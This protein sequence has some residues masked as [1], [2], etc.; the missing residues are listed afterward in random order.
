MRAQIEKTRD[1]GKDAQDS[2]RAVHSI[3]HNRG[4]GPIIPDDVDTPADD[5]FSSGNSPSLSHSSV[6]NSRESTKAKSRKRPSHLPAL[7]DVISGAF[8]RARKEVG[9]RQNQSVQVPRNASVLLEGTMPPALSA[10]MIPSMLFVHPAFG[11][12]PT[13]YMPPTAL[14]PLPD[15]MLSSPMGQHILD[16]E[17]P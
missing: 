17:P 1:L 6:K 3:A 9:K 7:S 4:K 14:I 16:Y 10:S 8:H 13:F 2:G 11:T 12:R 5:E 15:D